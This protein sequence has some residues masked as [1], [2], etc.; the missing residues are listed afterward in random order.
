MRIGT[1]NLGTPR[2]AS[3][4]EIERRL[5]RQVRFMAR[6]NCDIWLLTEVPLKFTMAPGE[7]TFSDEMSPFGVKA[8]AAVWARDGLNRLDPIHDAAAFA[9]VDD[10]RVCSC[11]FPWSR[12]PLPEWPDKAADRPLVTEMAIR[13]V[14]EGLDHGA[15]L[16]WGGDWNQTLHGRITTKPGRNALSKL[17]PALGL[18]VPT[19]VLAHTRNG[20]YCSIDHIAV[21]DS[22]NVTTASRLVGRFEG[23]SRLSDHD[24]YVI[25]V[26]R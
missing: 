16:V 23:G 3:P 20:G 17:L 10:L 12:A 1:W 4:K 26:E 19:A 25:E 14:G 9:T 5:A 11:V 15:D 2:S 18:K 24:A 8:Y 22:W 7:P 13:R 21:P 6:E